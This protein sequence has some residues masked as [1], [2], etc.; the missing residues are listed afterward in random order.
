MIV[1]CHTRAY[2][3]LRRA[4][5]QSLPHTSRPGPKASTATST[6]GCR[7]AAVQSPSLRRGVEAGDLCV[8]VRPR[9]RCSKELLPPRH[10][11]GAERRFAEVIDHDGQ[12]GVAGRQRRDVVE[13]V[14]VHGRQLEQE[15]ALLEQPQAL[16]DR[17]AEDPVRVRLLV[18][19]MPDPAELRAVL[20]LVQPPPR[21]ARVVEAAPADDRRDPVDRACDFEHVVGVFVARGA[22]DEDGRDRR[23]TPPTAARGRAARTSGRSPRARRSST[24]AGCDAD[25]R[26]VDGCRRPRGRKGL[27][28]KEGTPRD[29]R[30]APTWR[31]PS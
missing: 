11:V 12:A 29:P 5:G 10:L 23:R 30:A 17:G 20:Q 18:D 15:P 2:V 24:V 27:A 7:S 1:S 26:S 16:P 19:E 31:S 28:A 22:L 25:P 9:G 3:P 14:R 4:T 21:G 8:D 13:M 6:A